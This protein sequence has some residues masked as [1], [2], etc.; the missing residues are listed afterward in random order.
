VQQ[1]FD[2][3][4]SYS[5]YI[6]ADCIPPLAPDNALIAAQSGMTGTLLVSS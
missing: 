3:V 6:R 5:L 2:R 4:A 1:L